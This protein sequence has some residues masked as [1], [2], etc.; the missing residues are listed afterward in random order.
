[1]NQKNNGTFISH[2]K[3]VK[4]LVKK[5]GMESTAHQQTP[6]DT[7]DKISRDEEG[8]VIDQTLYRS[9]IG[10]L[11]CIIANIP[12]LCYS[13]GICARYQA[14]LK[15]SHLPVVK[16]IIKHD[17]GTIEFEL[18]YSCDSTKTLMGYCDAD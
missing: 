3:Y 6:I 1:M 10:S 7:H 2:T 8:K 12:D 11:L 18:W 16:K 17:S 14:N 13:V 5:F 15:E 4:A 9:M